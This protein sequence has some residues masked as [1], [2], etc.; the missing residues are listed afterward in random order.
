MYEQSYTV[1]ALLEPI[2]FSWRSSFG[3]SPLNVEVF[4]SS[5]TKAY[6]CAGEYDDYNTLASQH[7]AQ[8]KWQHSHK[9]TLYAFLKPSQEH[10]LRHPRVFSRFPVWPT[11]LSTNLD[12]GILSC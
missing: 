3:I 2:P 7:L 5:K 1:M 8:C 10:T 11:F 9:G 6:H 12:S 4:E